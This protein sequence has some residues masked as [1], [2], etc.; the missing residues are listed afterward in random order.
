[1]Q[2]EQLHRQLCLH[3]SDTFIYLD[4]YPSCHGNTRYNCAV[5]KT[6]QLGTGFQH[7][8]SFNLVYLLSFQMF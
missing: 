4:E 7:G 3:E 2:Q 6:H 1:M 8:N 5:E